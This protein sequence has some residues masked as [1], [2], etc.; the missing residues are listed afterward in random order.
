MKTL[1]KQLLASLAFLAVLAVS[2]PLHTVAAQ[3]AISIVDV[4]AFNPET[5]M[6]P[7]GPSQDYYPHIATVAQGGT[8]DFSDNGFEEHTIT[9]YTDKVLV[10]FEGVMVTMPVP[11]GKFDSGA[12]T[13]IE[14][15][16]TWTLDTS[17]L[18]PGDY[19][20]FCQFHPWMQATLR[21]V[22]GDTPTSAHVTIDHGLGQ[23][24]Q[25][26]AGS[27][28]WGFLPRNL[29]V[30]QG[31]MVAATNNGIVPHTLTSYT[32]TIQVV[33]GGHTLT[34]PVPDGVF[35]SGALGPTQS[36]TV[37]TSSLSKG[38][39]TYFCQFHPWMLGSLTVA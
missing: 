31:A 8:V 34:I 5:F 24:S 1:T 19:N 20:Y 25:F 13:P 33:E 39:H 9:S 26:F 11:D 21:V 36:Y 22:E 4:R 32:N 38:T 37:N 30:H 17:S 28:S 6:F 29:R 14:H 2:T 23:T 12:A 7:G 16:D 3:P 15:G 18:S 27:G 35:D 10:D